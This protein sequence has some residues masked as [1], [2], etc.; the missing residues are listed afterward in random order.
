MQSAKARLG[1]GPTPASPLSACAREYV[2]GNIPPNTNELVPAP[3]YRPLPGSGR[4]GAFVVLGVGIMVFLAQLASVALWVRPILVSSVW[5]GGGVMLAAALLTE[6][7][8]WPAVIAAGATGQTLLFL[9]LHLVTPTAAL[10]LGLLVALIT[11]AVASVL[12]AILRRPFTLSTLREF[13]DYCF[14]AVIGGAVGASI[15]FVASAELMRFRP[16]TFLT[17]RTFALSAVLG[18]LIV[19]PTVLLLVQWLRSTR[20]E[21][22]PRRVEACLLGGLLVLTSGLVFVQVARSSPTW[23]VFAATIPALLLWAAIRFGALGAS[24][25]LLAIALISSLGAAKG[26]PL[27]NNRPGGE[28]VLFLQLF[29]LGSGLPLL[30]MG[31]MMDEQK[32]TADALRFIRARLQSLNRDLIR[33]REEEATRIARELHDDVGQRLALVSIGLSRLRRAGQPSASGPDVKRLQE[34]TGAVVRS[35]RELSHR[36]HPA[37]L[38]HAGLLSALQMKC[39]EVCQ[40]TGMEVHLVSHGE[41]SGIP[42]DVALCLFRV[43]QE[44]LNNAVRHSGAHLVDL[45]LD[46]EGAELRLRVTDDGRGFSLGATRNGHGLGLHHLTER[47]GAVGGSLIV[48]SV[49]GSGT[50]LRVA[51]PLNGVLNA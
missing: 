7:R 30:G 2:L 22:P 21:V 14:V 17:W 47:L 37:V 18:Y 19:T 13:R 23:P 40:A 49:P 36:L 20:Q 35:L 28:N 5:L 24:T 26:L 15:L 11:L 9:A 31:V 42:P 29:L 45:S 12:G 41:T 3:D 51:V 25:S 8:N 44:A 27:L 6:R 50:T 4:A 48:E 1:T 10:L 16:V 46:R 38:E 43:A 33:A 39:D 34:Q 32:R